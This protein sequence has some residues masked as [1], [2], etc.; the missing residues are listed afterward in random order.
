M[1]SKESPY[2]VISNPTRIIVQEWF[3]DKITAKQDVTMPIFCEAFNFLCENDALE[4][5][6][7]PLS[8]NNIPS[9]VRTS[10]SLRYEGWRRNEGVQYW[11][12]RQANFVVD[13]ATEK[14]T[15][16]IA[17][18]GQLGRKKKTAIIRDS[19]W[20]ELTVNLHQVINAQKVERFAVVGPGMSLLHVQL[21]QHAINLLKEYEC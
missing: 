21:F 1:E 13:D 20:K 10:I 9:K 7:V 19:P 18:R 15:V 11:A 6:M 3:Q 8:S 17:G 12:S 16:N 5:F 4:A 14:V 2:A